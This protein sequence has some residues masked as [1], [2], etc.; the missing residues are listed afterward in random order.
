MRF[1]MMF[2]PMIFRQYQKYQNK[3]QREQYNQGRIPQNNRQYQQPQDN[4]G[5]HSQRSNQPNQRDYQQE[6]PKDGRYYR[7]NNEQPT[8]QQ[9]QPQR[10]SPARKKPPVLS[11]DEKNF[12]LKEEEF[13]LDPDTHADYKKEM[14][15]I[16]KNSKMNHED[17]VNNKQISAERSSD[18]D[19]PVNKNTNPIEIEDDGFNIRDLF[20]KPD[21]E[22][23][24]DA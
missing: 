24:T 6:A 4:R 12:N 9:Q 19:L 15:A 22:T 3:K 23:E 5:R 21:D 7:G 10:P 17:I 1:L 11:E 18:G 20:L 14:D 2:G 13:M 16:E 8:R